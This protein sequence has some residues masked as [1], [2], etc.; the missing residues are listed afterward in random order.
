MPNWFMKYVT[1]FSS[2]WILLSLCNLLTAYAQPIKVD[3]Y[4]T[5]GV[6]SGNTTYIGDLNQRPF[7]QNSFHV[8]LDYEQRRSPHWTLRSSATWSRLVGN[9]FYHPVSSF[10]YLRNLHFR[11]DVLAVS[12]GF[13][14]D[15]LKSLGHFSER[16]PFTPYISA[17]FAVFHHNPKAKTPPSLG[18]LWINLQ[19]LGTEGQGRDGFQANYRLWDIAIPLGLGFRYKIARRFDL[20]VEATYHFTRSDYLDDVG[21]TYAN[22]SLFGDDQLSRLMA[23]RSME[24]TNVPTGKTRRNFN[25][26]PFTE[27]TPRGTK[28]GNDAWLSVSIGIKYLLTN[29]KNRKELSRIHRLVDP[30]NPNPFPLTPKQK[31]P[32]K[33]KIHEDR[34]E[35]TNLGINTS[36]SEM[37]PSFYRNGIMYVSDKQGKK[38]YVKGLRNNFYNFFYSPLHDVM[39]NKLNK[40]VKINDRNFLQYHHASA[41]NI[42]SSDEMIIE[43]YQDNKAYEEKKPHKLYYAKTVAEDLLENLRP[44]PFNS[45]DYSIAQPAIDVSETTIVFASDMP[46]G[47]G[48]T[49]LYVSYNINGQW[50]YPVNLGPKI[51]TTGDEMFP[52]FHSDSTLYFASNGHPGMG[53]FDI[54]EVIYSIDRTEIDSI[55]N[56]G[57][58]I[59]SE[60]DDF[61][62]ILDDVKRTGF[63]CSN[64]AG[65]KGGFDLYKL[66]VLKI[67]PTRRLTAQGED[68]IGKVELKLKGFVVNKETK[69]RLPKAIVRL[70]NVLEDAFTIVKA[71]SLGE[72]EFTIHNDAIYEIGSSAIGFEPMEDR[73]I[74]TV[75][76]SEPEE[77]ES[78]LDLYPIRYILSVHGKVRDDKTGLP[79]PNAK[80]SLIYVDEKTQEDYFAND[81]GEYDIELVKGKKYKIIITKDGYLPKEYDLNT[82]LKRRN[83]EKTVF[84]TELMSSSAE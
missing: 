19:P 72:F 71:D 81:E 38:N 30:A 56:V 31:I 75:D 77:I 64:R 79:I 65:G 23:D 48:G 14:Y 83:N 84:F 40:M 42:A 74:S 60:A 15:F 62:L 82:S 46:G 55:A 11:N 36:D 26:E 51:N 59:N 10:E 12:V 37:C 1:L 54:Y 61:G 13:Q 39:A 78:V 4:S 76:I 80:I 21:G 58:P 44:L 24:K 43:I 32:N 7:Q 57:Y 66:D 20:A 52:Y 49:D 27:G 9:D 3:R 22:P 45:A 8:S 25:T 16:K 28:K 69:K 53:G 34:F 33:F 18:N 50:T 41:C 29:T 63:F 73:L 68:M 47:F 2:W 5:I 6:R 17:G 35:V 67:S 70:R